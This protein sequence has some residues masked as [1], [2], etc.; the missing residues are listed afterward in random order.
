LTVTAVALAADMFIYGVAIPVLPRIASSTG[1][2]ASG[3][4]ILFACYAL[5]MLVATPLAGWLID[6][7]GH[8]LPMIAGLFALAASTLLFAT[9][10]LF[11]FLMLARVLQGVSAAVA[12][13]AGLALISTVFPAEER[14]KP[15]GLALSAS[16][17]GVLLGPAVGGFMADHWGMQAP[18]I[19]AAVVVLLD[20]IARLALVRDGEHA[21]AERPGQVWRHPSTGLMFALTAL[22]AGLIAF[23]E[24]ILPL[25]AA[26]TFS[27]SSN[28]IGLIFAG[29]VLAGA[30]AASAGG[31]LA[32]K[33]P[34]RVLAAIG[35]FI[36]AVGLLIT[37]MAGAIWLIAVGLALV[38]IGAQLTLV[39]TI[40]LISMIADD[41]SPPAYGAAYSLYNIAYTAGLMIAPLLAAAGSAVTS[42]AWLT[43]GAAVLAIVIALITTLSRPRS[44]VRV[45]S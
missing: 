15:L 33:L 7:I 25:H 43:V 6:R 8:R 22:G 20:G 5:A 18:F 32:D 9:V 36:A 44:A 35:A 31:Y 4:S 41:Q 1:V 34:R 16:G 28:T 27:A 42:F 37:G 30:V 21:P 45:G 17:I 11:P 38:T 12:W 10:Q 23:L 29:A 3:V 39:T 40:A 2:N 24:P 26:S 13:T 14:G 19:L